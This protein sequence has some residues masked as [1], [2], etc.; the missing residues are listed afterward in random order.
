MLDTGVLAEQAV[1]SKAVWMLLLGV[2][3]G[4]DYLSERSAVTS[5]VQGFNQVMV[6]YDRA[7]QRHANTIA[8]KDGDP[9][10]QLTYRSVLAEKLIP[11]Y[12]KIIQMTKEMEPKTDTLKQIRALQLEVFETHLQGL[13]TQLKGLESADIS[14]CQRGTERLH[15]GRQLIKKANERYFSYVARFGISGQ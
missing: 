1:S 4:C 14:L 8:D 10:M 13:R 11:T 5:Y 12:E 2:V 7:W 3:A 9:C 6:Y 15:A